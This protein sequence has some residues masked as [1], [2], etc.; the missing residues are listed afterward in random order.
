[1]SSPIEGIGIVDTM[2]GIPELGSKTYKFLDR[3]IL[4]L[5]AA[6]LFG[7]SGPNGKGPA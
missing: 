3:K 4:G 2:I 7:L 6:R 1:M 5:N